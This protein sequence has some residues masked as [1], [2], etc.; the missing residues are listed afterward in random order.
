MLVPVITAGI[1]NVSLKKKTTKAKQRG[2]VTKNVR[3]KSDIIF[4]YKQAKIMVP[5]ITA[6]MI[7]VSLSK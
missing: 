4:V 3:F 6:G 1:M 2:R 7:N 5:V